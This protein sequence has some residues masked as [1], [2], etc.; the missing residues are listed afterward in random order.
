MIIDTSQLVLLAIPGVTLWVVSRLLT[1]VE[2]GQRNKT[3]N[4]LVLRWIAILLMLLG[5]VGLI[6]QWVSPFGVTLLPFLLFGLL[7]YLFLSRRATRE[8]F[9]G[10]IESA[11]VMGV[12]VTPLAV[13]LAAH[14]RGSKRRQRKFANELVAGSKPSEAF[15]NSKLQVAVP[16][17]VQGYT[18]DEPMLLA[19]HLDAMME[20]ERAYRNAVRRTVESGLYLIAVLLV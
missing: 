7:S 20:E 12:D 1:M 6:S 10:C 17:Q 19:P 11:M 18:M 4:G 16:M 2:L 15:R 5:L 13:S 14:S 8:W 9:V 3:A